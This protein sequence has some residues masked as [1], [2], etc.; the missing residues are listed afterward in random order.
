MQKYTLCVPFNLCRNKNAK[1]N[2]FLLLYADLESF[3]CYNPLKNICFLILYSILW[4]HDKN[5]RK[6]RLFSSQKVCVA[7][8]LIICCFSLCAKQLKKSIKN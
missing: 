8:F 7:N 6:C 3:S 5:S 1:K 4:M 2:A